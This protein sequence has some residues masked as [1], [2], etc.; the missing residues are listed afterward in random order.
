M[1]SVLGIDGATWE[2]IEKFEQELPNFKRLRQK[3]GKQTL[4]VEDV[5][6]SAALW[7]TIFSGKSFA[8]HKHKKFVVNNK[9]RTR[10]DIKVNFIWDE[11]KKRNINSIAL[12]IPFV[13]PPYNFGSNYKPYAQGGVTNNL[14]ELSQDTEGILL[15][16]IRLINKKKPKAFFVVFAALD[17]V[18]HFHWG[19][20]DVLLPWYKKMDEIVA[21]FDKLADKLII[22]SD[23][24]F[25]D[26]GKAKK[27]TL[28]PKT[29]WGK[30][31]GD[32]FEEAIL[33]TKN[34]GCKIKKHRDIFSAVI[35]ELNVKLDYRQAGANQ[36]TKNN[37]VKSKIF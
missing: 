34:I 30:I 12:Q 2:M 33:I 35:A 15:E 29:E 23:H 3:F 18:Q 17:K 11:L 37:K 27:T 20:K 7:T 10:D 21:I 13:Y 31:K 4:K 26:R 22:L 32:H 28:P 5:V 14:D 25:C 19:E 1:L 6:L 9:L 16:S 8:E 36:K 24:G